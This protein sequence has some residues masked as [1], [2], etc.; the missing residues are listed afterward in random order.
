MTS[1]L[2]PTR[3]GRLAERNPVMKLAAA[4]VPTVALVATTDAVTPAVVLAVLLV[5]LP[6]SGVATGALLRRAWLL[7]VAAVMV[8][9]VN[10]LV[11]STTTGRSLFDAGPFHLTTGSAQVGVGITL[12]VLAIALPGVLVLSATDPVDLA[13]SLVQQARAPARFAY[14]TLAALRLLP[15][16]GEEWQTLAMARRARGFDAGRSPVGVLRLFGS[17]VFALLVGAIRRG[18]RLA[19]A[20]DARGFDSGLPRTFARRQVV[21]PA[22]VGLV[23][24]AVLT[25]G[26]AAAVSMA[27]G[28][29][30]PLV[31]VVT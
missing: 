30:K 12:R 24:A 13:D 5:A 26:V 3:T 22:D 1:L 18:T 11:G 25:I 17:Q 8:G 9:V 16:L 31:A 10:A 4:T 23:A 15:L 19:T 14:G 6:Y 27:V 28:A 7:L 21:A 2:E 20:M 29:W